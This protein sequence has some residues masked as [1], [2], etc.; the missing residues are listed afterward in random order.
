MPGS[1][2]SIA[3]ATEKRMM[4]LE[5]AKLEAQ[6]RSEI[7]SATNSLKTNLILSS[8]YILLFLSLPVVNPVASMIVVS[9]LKSLVP[10]LTT[11]SNFEKSKQ[12]LTFR[13]MKERVW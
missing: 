5:A 6:R 11:I 1:S 10:V 12:L 2:P 3:D 8:F 4:N 7:N 9:L 13:W